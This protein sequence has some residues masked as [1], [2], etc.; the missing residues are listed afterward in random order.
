MKNDPI[1]PAWTG[2][3]IHWALSLVDASQFPLPV[4]FA[5]TR[6]QVFRFLAHELLSSSFAHCALLLGFQPL[7]ACLLRFVP[8]A[9][10]PSLQGFAPLSR[11][12]FRINIVRPANAGL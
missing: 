12:R 7:C 10:L 11:F 9:F 2:L 1:D 4:A 8:P 5:R 6:T 3:P